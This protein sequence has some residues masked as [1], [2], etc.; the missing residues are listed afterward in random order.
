MILVIQE[1][2]MIQ[3]FLIQI[4][5]NVFTRLNG[6]MVLTKRDL[7]DIQKLLDKQEENFEKKVE[8]FKND[9]FERIDPI[10]K[11]VVTAREE[12]PLL[13]NRLEALEEIHQEGQHSLNN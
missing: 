1:K 2:K 13:E 12:K 7:N 8:D 10:L 3:F 9:F 4:D 11:E 5:T 6:G